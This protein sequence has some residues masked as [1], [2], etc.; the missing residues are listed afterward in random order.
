MR[1][2][3]LLVRLAFSSLIVSLAACGG[4]KKVATNTIPPPPQTMPRPLPTPPVAPPAGVLTKPVAVQAEGI[5]LWSDEFLYA[6]WRIQRH[7]YDSRSRLVDA[8]GKLRAVGMYAQVKLAFD[9]LRYKEKVKPRSTHLVL[10]LHG[11]ASNPDVWNSMQKTLDQDGWEARTITY[12]TTEQGV[13]PNGDVLENLL[14]HQEGYADIAIV[15]HSLGGLVTRAAVSRP[16]FTT[17]PVPVTRIVMLGTPNQGAV[18]A[19]MLRP[20]ARAAVTASAN[21][22]LPER[23]RQFGAIPPQVIFGVIAGG[24]NAST[25]FNPLLAGDN[26]SIVKVTEA[27]TQNMDDF[28]ILPVMHTKMTADPGVIARV[29]LFL[30]TG[31]FRPV[32]TKPVS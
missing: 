20:I 17:L 22:L 26:D 19:E 14:K 24:R 15:A 4:N 23:A 27:R 25:G 3:G 9:Y 11:L 29:R 32:S 12:P 16:S 18:L 13:A 21:D 8:S 7:F 30:R 10:L 31:G 6:G 1:L 2:R 5:S 28:I